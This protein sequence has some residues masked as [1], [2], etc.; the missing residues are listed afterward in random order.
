MLFE[1]ITKKPLFPGKDE[2]DQIHRINNVLGTPR[3]ELLDRF[4]SQA[5]HME[6]NFPPKKGT[7]LD[8]FLPAGCT[9]DLKDILAKLLTYDPSERISAENAIRHEYFAEFTSQL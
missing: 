3:Q 7:G 5:T 9:Q 4:K 8:K 2:L 1:L 6:I